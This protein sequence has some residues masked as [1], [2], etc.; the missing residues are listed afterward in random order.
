MNDE[1]NRGSPVNGRAVEMHIP[2]DHERSQTSN[3][4][5]PS[6]FCLLDIPL[7]FIGHGYPSSPTKERST[8]VSEP[9]HTAGRPSYDT[10]TLD[11][12][13]AVN[14]GEQIITDSGS[15]VLYD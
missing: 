9:L 3:I 1:G 8:R 2:I 14:G 7:F 11:R 13:P 6:H 10:H 12:R 4:L 5:S 15:T